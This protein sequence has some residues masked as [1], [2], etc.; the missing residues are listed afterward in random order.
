MTTVDRELTGRV[1]KA[2]YL[3]NVSETMTSQAEVD[4]RRMMTS[5]SELRDE[6]ARLG[7]NVSRVS[8]V[9]HDTRTRAHDLRVSAPDSREK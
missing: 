6:L 4:S 9:T 2:V 5:L 7:R 1:F 3:L 8:D